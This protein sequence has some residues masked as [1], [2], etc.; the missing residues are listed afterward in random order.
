MANKIRQAPGNW[1]SVDE[2]KASAEHTAIAN[3]ITGFTPGDIDVT[4]GY[5][6]EGNKIWINYNFDTDAK[7]LEFKTYL[8]TTDSIA[9]FGQSL[10]DL[11][12]ADDKFATITSWTV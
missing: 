11:E 8:N 12:L 6:L 9:G 5:I 3:A 1:A 2:F 7:L 4:M 10:R